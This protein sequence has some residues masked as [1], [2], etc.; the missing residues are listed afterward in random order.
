VTVTP[1]PVITLSNVQTL[2]SGI[3]HTLAASGANTYTWLPFNMNGSVIAVSPTASTCYTVTGTGA[4]GCKGS[5]A[6]CFSVI[7]TPTITI[8]GN[9]PLCQ[10]ESQ[11]LTASGANNYTW[12]PGG[13]S[14]A[15]VTMTPSAG[16]CYTV[17]G[18]DNSG[19]A[20][21][22]V[23]CVTLSPQAPLT[24]SGTTNICKNTSTSFVVS[25]ASSYTWNTGSNSATISVSPTV[26]TCYSV[27]GT[28]TTGCIRTAT[29]CVNVVSNPVISVSGNTSI[30][31]GQTATLLASGASTYTWSTG[32]TTPSISVTPASST[33]LTVNGQNS[34]G[35]PGTATVNIYVN[36]FPYIFVAPYDSVIC[37]G[38]S[39]TLKVSGAQSYSWNNGAQTGTIT[40]AP[41]AST[42]MVVTGTSGVCHRS[43]SLPITVEPCTGIASEGGVSGITVF[44]N[45]ARAFITIKNDRQSV[46]QFA[47]FDIT[48]RRIL[49]GQFTNAKTLDLSDLS[50]G[51][52]I[53][54]FDSDTQTGYQRVIL[55]K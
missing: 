43:S 44:P 11:N 4:G 2:C 32:A 23:T 10:G 39:I 5:A 3:N 31:S 26:N 51:M 34:I 46:V 20:A 35:C 15:S 40:I 50:N 28:G 37:K 8:S 33:S 55:E 52:Y 41:A 14:G 19:C 1:N 36:G 48:G 42:T 47:L 13:L 16:T 54:R 27:T 21:S 49:N 29:V 7:P 38:D 24:V 6:S 45:P 18:T 12:F 22:A 17:T 9:A 30:C 53:I 25:G